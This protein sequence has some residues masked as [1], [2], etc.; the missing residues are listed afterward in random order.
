MREL[1]TVT[2]YYLLVSALSPPH[3]KAMFD[4]VLHVLKQANVY[5]YRKSGDH[6]SG[7]MVI[8]YIDVVIHIFSVQTRQY[9]AIEEL[10]KAAR[11]VDSA[12]GACRSS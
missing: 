3:L 1:S 10:W 12:P 5:S 4:E 8:D 9:Y 11:H 2:D 7:W 6:G